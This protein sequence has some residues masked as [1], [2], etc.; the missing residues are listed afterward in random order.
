[1][2]ATSEFREPHDPPTAT[3]LIDRVLDRGIVIDSEYHIAVAGVQLMT[4]DMWLVVASL[5]T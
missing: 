5:E 4:I 1:M 3:D 2:N